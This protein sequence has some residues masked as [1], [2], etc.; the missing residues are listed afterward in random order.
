MAGGEFEYRGLVASAYDLFTS[1]DKLGDREFFR[2]AIERYGQPALEIGCGTGRLLIPFRAADLEVE[3]VDSSP[4]M[5]ALCRRK[6]EVGGFTVALYPQRMQELDFPRRYRTLYIPAA[7][8]M[9]L[10][11]ADE[12][13][14]ALRG[15]HHHLEPGGAPPD[16]PVSSLEA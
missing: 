13:E 3:G 16:Q 10:R 4:E 9:L 14:Q 5:L 1:E 6:A 15:F 11:R 8:F 7:T 2:Q 12:I